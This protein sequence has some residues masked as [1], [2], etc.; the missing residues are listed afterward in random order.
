MDLVNDQIV[1][2]S[3]GRLF[4]VVG[5]GKHQHKVTTGEGILLFKLSKNVLLI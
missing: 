2:N 3:Y 1:A 5:I 4:A